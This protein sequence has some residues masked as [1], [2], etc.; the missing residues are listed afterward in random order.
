MPAIRYPFNA[1]FPVATA[2]PGGTLLV[3]SKDGG[4]R[5]LSWNGFIC[6]HATAQISGKYC[7][8]QASD[9]T[10]DSGFVGSEWQT[11]RRT[12]FVLGWAVESL[13]WGQQRHEWGV[14]AIIDDTCLPIIIDDQ[15]RKPDKEVERAPVIRIEAAKRIA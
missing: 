4:W 8:I 11:L 10:R 13:K 6:R 2:A 1:V 14:Y 9:V 3:R 12:E 5:P 15:G 7:K